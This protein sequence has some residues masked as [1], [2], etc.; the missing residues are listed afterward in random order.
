MDTKE[1]FAQILTLAMEITN[2]RKAKTGYWG[3]IL[4]YSATGCMK[5]VL[6]HKIYTLYANGER[7]LQPDSDPERCIRDLRRL[8]EDAQ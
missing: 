5:V 3:H 4:Y 6:P 1:Q 7:H 2:L 8:L